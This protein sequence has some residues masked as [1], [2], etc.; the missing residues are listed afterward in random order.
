MPTAPAGISDANSSLGGAGAPRHRQEPFVPADLPLVP[1]VLGLK[2]H[3]RQYDLVCFDEVA[4]VSFDQKN[5]VKILKGEMA[6]GEFSRSKESIRAEGGNVMVSIFDVGV[7]QQ[8]RI[9]HLLSPLSSEMRDNT[10]CHARLHAYAPGWDFH[11][12]NL[13]EHFTSHLG[14][15]CDFF[16]ECLRR[17]RE[18]TRVFALQNR[19]HLGGSL[20]G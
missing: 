19:V 18:S 14:L 12:L 1:P 17:L 5:G 8:Q 2:G 10:T 3:R 15:V 13:N 6:S 7:E 4:G 16:I 20:T 11:K 9:G